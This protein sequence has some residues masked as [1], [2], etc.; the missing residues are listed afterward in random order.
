MQWMF[1]WKDYLI[2]YCQFI[3]MNAGLS[4]HLLGQYIFYDVNELHYINGLKSYHEQCSGVN[5]FLY[6]LYRYFVSGIA[7]PL[8]YL[9]NKCGFMISTLPLRIYCSQ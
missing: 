1:L 5:K 7:S 4:V 6:I 2:I 8:D 3:E 9:C